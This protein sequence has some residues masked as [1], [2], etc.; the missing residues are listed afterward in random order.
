MLV[1]VCIEESGDERAGGS[2]THLEAELV[3]VLVES[4]VHQSSAEAVVGKQ[5]EYGLENL[6]NV[7]QVLSVNHNRRLTLLHLKCDCH[8]QE[9][10]VTQ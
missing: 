5:Q 2:C 3:V 7:S 8:K 4:D 9:I 1:V 10:E 6:V